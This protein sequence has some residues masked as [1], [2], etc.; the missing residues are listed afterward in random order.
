MPDAS[1]RPGSGM[2]DSRGRRGPEGAGSRVLGHRQGSAGPG[3][4]VGVCGLLS[5]AGRDICALTQG[6]GRRTVGTWA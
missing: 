5:K 3:S 1:S 6:Q 2:Q 4:Q